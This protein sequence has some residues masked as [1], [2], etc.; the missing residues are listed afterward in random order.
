SIKVSCTL[1]ADMLEDLRGRAV[2][3]FCFYP[4]D[5]NADIE[6]RA[7]VDFAMAKDSFTFTLDP[8]E[9]PMFKY[10]KYIMAY[11]DGEDYI[12]MG[13]VAY[14]EDPEALAP[15]E[16][17]SVATDG[18]I[19]MAAEGEY[20][21]DKLPH[22]IV[23][24]YMNELFAD[25]ADGSLRYEYGDSVYYIDTEVLS[26]LDSRIGYFCGEGKAVYLQL[27]LAAPDESTAKLTAD[28]YAD[29]AE[30]S[31]YAPDTEDERAM[32]LWACLTE[33]L[34]ERYAA[35]GG[36]SAFILG[37]NVNVMD[38]YAL[39][40]DSRDGYLRSLGC[41]LRVTETAVRSVCRGVD[42]YLSLSGAF[43]GSHT[44]VYPIRD[45][46]ENVS[47]GDLG[48]GIYLD[49]SCDEPAFW[50]DE[51]VRADV[52]TP[53]ITPK[54][55][56]FFISYMSSEALLYRSQPRPIILG[57]STDGTDYRDQSASTLCALYR[58]LSVEGLKA[59]IYNSY[60]D[61]EG[62]STGMLSS[63]GLPKEVYSQLCT[64][65]DG[66]AASVGEQ[67]RELMHGE[68]YESLRD[69][70]LSDLFIIRG[71]LPVYNGELAADVDA[72][73]L[74]DFVDAGVNS[75]DF[76]RQTLTHGSTMDS[77]GKVLRLTAR[78]DTASM[79]RTY[80]KGYDLNDKNVMVVELKALSE[81]AG[82]DFTL[83]LDGI[84]DGEGVS[85]T[86]TVHLNSGE[87]N[88]CAFD[89]SGI[90]TLTGMSLT[91]RSSDGKALT[92]YIKDITVFTTGM[93][94]AEMAVRIAVG[95]LIAVIALFIILLLILIRMRY[96]KRPLPT[97]RYTVR[98][99]SADPTAVEPSPA[100]EKSEPAIPVMPKTEAKT[101]VVPPKHT[102][103]VKRDTLNVGIDP[104]SPD[105]D[106]D[107]DKTKGEEN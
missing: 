14:L 76:G 18:V 61:S 74:A 73:D 104:V 11:Q 36:V 95:V 96:R 7:P 97:V 10:G 70:V 34:C 58:G 81:A 65:A 101:F 56:D 71:P 37:E 77:T 16:K 39:G 27:L 29:G 13:N 99:R 52:A 40:T 66:D 25:T 50:L 72:M 83:V 103:P 49:I 8:D 23:P 42:V 4:G 69:S 82:A 41:T 12:L 64:A 84:K 102:E 89:V 59:F 17:E 19:G 78:T 2:Y 60:A 5:K 106:I 43:S 24:V 44:G 54:N 75:F 47:R 100:P 63:D 3:L 28:L 92:W 68:E 21:S 90:D 38:N 1:S 107:I 53:V 20:T 48:F 26:R 15:V 33:F 46:I 22:R 51:S 32:R 9:D 87:W 105:D 86:S 45:V 35:R 98:R 30:G 88:E 79:S 80:D 93:G 94:M 57:Y 31:L 6:R 62:V 55:L 67:I 91:V 85:L